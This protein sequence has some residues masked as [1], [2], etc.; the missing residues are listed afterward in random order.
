MSEKIL[1]EEEINKLNKDKYGQFFSKN[2]VI[3]NVIQ[4]LISNKGTIMEP[5]VG[6]GDLIFGL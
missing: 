5:S 1:T 4:S 3:R 2:P 6:E